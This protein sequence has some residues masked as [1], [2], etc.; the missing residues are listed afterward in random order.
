MTAFVAF[1]RSY[2]VWLYLVCALGILVGI[3]ILTDAQRL[4]RTTLFSLEQERAGEQTF[5]AI[6]L[7]VVVLLATGSVTM[8]ILLAPSIVPAPESPVLR[9]PTPTFVALVFPTSTAVPSITATLIKPSETPFVT[10]TPV[11]NNTPVRSTVRPT[12]GPPPATP[13]SAFGLPAPQLIGP[14]N[15]MVVTGF[16]NKSTSLTFKWVW[17]CAQCALG[18]GDNYVI[19]INY[20]DRG[21]KPMSVGGGPRENYITMDGIIRGY[22]VDIYQQAK[23]DTYYWTV[24]V[25]RGEQPLT[26]P[27]ETWKFVWH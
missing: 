1:V 18:P 23:D 19:S 3:K 8:I 17:D 22:P 5:R 12:T 10:S 20:T 14:P 2:A 21:G 4:A 11:I 9:G 24:Q 15:A 25:K 7:I 6:T 27:S 16:T 26:P 13:A